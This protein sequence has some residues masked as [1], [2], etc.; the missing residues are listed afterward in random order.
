MHEHGTCTY[1]HTGTRTTHTHVHTSH[2]HPALKL[3][4][5]ENREDAP[6]R[7]RLGVLHGYLMVPACQN[8]PFFMQAW[9][10]YDLVSPRV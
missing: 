1:A 10:G 7:M 3:K 5:K 9:L 2:T 4:V 8:P 6:C